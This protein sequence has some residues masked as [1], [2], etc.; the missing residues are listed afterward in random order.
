M[1]ITDENAGEEMERALWQFIEIAAA[2]PSERPDDRT[3]GHVMAYMPV[4]KRAEIIALWQ[5][6]H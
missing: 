1:T 3:W 2:F 4:E 6:S 5:S